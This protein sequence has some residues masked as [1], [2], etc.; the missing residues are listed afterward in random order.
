MRYR[1]EP[2]QLDSLVALGRLIRHYWSNGPA[3]RRFF[4]GCL[5]RALRTSPRLIGQMI[6]CMGMY[7]HFCQVR[8]QELDWDPWQ[9]QEDEPLEPDAPIPLPEATVA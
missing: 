4:W 2:L 6:I 3:S 9:V 7:L 1:P 8:A 5:W